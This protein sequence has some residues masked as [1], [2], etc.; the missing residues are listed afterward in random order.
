MNAWICVTCGTQF[1]PSDTPPKSCPI[2]SEERQYVGYQGQKWTTLDEMKAKAYK[3]AYQQY[4]PNLIGIGT[5]PEFGIGQR[6]LLIRT[7]EGNIL[8]DCI[9]YIDDITTDIIRGL[10]G[11]K[12]IAISHP[13]YY[14]AM[15]EWAHRFDCPIYLHQNDREWVM[16]PSDRIQFWNGEE[17]PLTSETKL[18]HVGGHFAGGTVL[19]WRNGANGR[20]VL[21]AGDIV[22]VVT[23]RKWVSFM[24]SYPNVIPLPVREIER[25]KS[26]LEPIEFER[27]YGFTFDRVVNQDAKECVMRSAERY[28]R[29]L[30]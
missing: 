23:D 28:I 7:P 2:C 5:F 25:I 20:G 29:A 9:T 6:A 15:V 19:H 22:Q 14:S 30:Q 13:H 12:A 21:L 11:V 17:L 10:G 18:I 16:R 26:K 1:S 8:W 27:L 4:E 3:N 24:Y